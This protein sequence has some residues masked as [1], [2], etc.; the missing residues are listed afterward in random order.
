MDLGRNE[1]DVPL[2]QGADLVNPEGPKA[3]FCN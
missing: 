3:L 1:V 2:E